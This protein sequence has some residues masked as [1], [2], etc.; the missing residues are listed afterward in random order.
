MKKISFL[1]KNYYNNK[2]QLSKILILKILKNIVNK[3]KKVLIFGMGHD[4]IL[5]Y[6]ANN[7]KNI[8]FVESDEN[9]INLNS[10]INKKNIIK[11]K[12]KNINVFKSLKNEIDPSVYE[13]PQKLERNKPFDVILIDAPQGYADNLPGREIPYYWSRYK[14]M[15]SKTKIYMD[16]IKRPLEL[17]LL[18]K[19]YFDFQLQYFEERNG[20]ACVFL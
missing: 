1:M 4:S 11:Y 12:Y 6:K 3:N 16:D 13:L 8:F 20:S 18:K 5:W 15:H 9:Y 7:S 14:L 2:I 17:H 19:Y 10:E